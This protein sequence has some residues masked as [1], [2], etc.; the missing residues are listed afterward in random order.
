MA[1][2]GGD[3]MS[4]ESERESRNILSPYRVTNWPRSI[5]QR[6]KNKPLNQV[7]I[8]LFIGSVV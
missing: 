2:I 8:L 3:T 6:N 5:K 4:G 7:F 1:T